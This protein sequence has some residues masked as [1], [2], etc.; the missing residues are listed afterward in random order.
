MFVLCRCGTKQDFYRTEEGLYSY[1]GQLY[2]NNG[3]IALSE[4]EQEYAELIEEFPEGVE[5]AEW[6]SEL[7]RYSDWLLLGMVIHMGVML[8]FPICKANKSL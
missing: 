6:Y 3:E 7:Y 4:K 5:G 1:N 8:S 2:E